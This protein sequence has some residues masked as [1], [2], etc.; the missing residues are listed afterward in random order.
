METFRLAVEDIKFPVD[1]LQPKQTV[2]VLDDGLNLT[3]RNVAGTLGNRRVVAGNLVEGD[4]LAAVEAA[5]SVPCAK[6]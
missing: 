1:S 5:E 6:P 4:E 3:R 2:G